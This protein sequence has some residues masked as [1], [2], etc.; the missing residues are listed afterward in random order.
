MG[1]R[2]FLLPDP[3]EGLTEAEIV[4]W[5]VAVGDVV[6]V[7]DIVVEIETA[8]S[9]VELPIPWAGT[10]AALLAPE[11][12]TVEVGSAIIAID[13]PTYAGS[14]PS[15][16]APAGPAAAPVG[17]AS[18]SPSA[19]PSLAAMAAKPEGAGGAGAGQAAA[20][21]DE[22]VA[23]GL[24][25]GTTSTG[26]TAVLVGYGIKQT[27][28]VRRPRRKDDLVRTVAAPP[29]KDG[30]HIEQPPTARMG[31]LVAAHAPEVRRDTRNLTE[32]A[33]AGGANAPASPARVLAKPPVRKYA[34]DLGVDLAHV[35]APGGIVT[36]ADIDAYIHG[37]APEETVTAAAYASGMPVS[38]FFGSRASPTAP[39]ESGRG[40]RGGRVAGSAGGTT[41]GSV[42]RIEWRRRAACCNEGNGG[43]TIRS[44]T[45]TAAR[46]RPTARKSPNVATV[47]RQRR[48]EGSSKILR[49]ALTAWLPGRVVSGRH[50]AAGAELAPHLVHRTVEQA[51]CHLAAEAP[52]SR[53][54]ATAPAA[55]DRPRRAARVPSPA[56]RDTTWTHRVAGAMYR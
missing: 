48:R 11:G 42:S 44:E 24:I 22:S 9:L 54:P 21:A 2:E 27:E 50:S 20:A 43:F 16:P 32:L 5:R 28:A 12:A 38:P 47:H 3:G 19:S 55:R 46:P 13:D 52:R 45:K 6:K 18:S 41:A 23:E 29:D 30:G 8:K 39:R 4:T 51:G 33:Q 31:G 1:I 56:L 40:E 7:N 25:G 15:A 37:G 10:V 17:S 49:V 53:Q 34:K 35:P 26:R 14:P 36:R